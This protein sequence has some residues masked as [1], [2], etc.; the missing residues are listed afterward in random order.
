MDALTT[1]LTEKFSTFE[2]EHMRAFYQNEGSYAI[3]EKP[4]DG[5]S[6]QT[7]KKDFHL[8]KAYL[9]TI[10]GIQ[11]GTSLDKAE[12]KLMECAVGETSQGRYQYAQSI[13]D[14]LMHYSSNAETRALAK[15]HRLEYL[16]AV[17][18]YQQ[19][20][21]PASDGMQFFLGIAPDS[22][23]NPYELDF[24]FNHVVELNHQLDAK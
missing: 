12:K 8:P 16:K 5:R 22:F 2:E 19:Q 11:P 15:E 17:E 3:Q 23:T 6:S 1:L 18:D 9:E 24:S 20:K 4:Q 7:F 13:F 21:F 10:C 14:S